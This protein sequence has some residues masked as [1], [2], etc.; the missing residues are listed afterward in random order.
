MLLV[1]SL[2]TYNNCSR[3]GG[4]V[5][6]RDRRLDWSTKQRFAHEIALGMALVHSLGRMHRDLKSGNVLVTAAGGT[7]RL[8]VADFG[9]ATLLDMAKGAAVHV[10][11]LDELVDSPD[12]RS[13]SDVND[14]VR[15]KGVG[16]PLWMA[17]EV[18]AGSEDYAS[19]ADVYSYAIVMW[20]IASQVYPWADVQGSFLGNKILK[21]L[22]DGVRPGID[23]GWPAT[24]VL[25]MQAAWALQPADRPTFAQL[26]AMLQG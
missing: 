20:E 21:L 9:T 16:T 12:V 14:R 15:T 5:V 25:A 6:L 7:M 19:S 18:L 1:R 24:Y 8:K 10:M 26:A 3:L 2:S 17:P 23:I 11:A 22:R 4:S 13:G